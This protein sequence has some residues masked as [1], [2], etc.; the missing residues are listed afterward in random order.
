MGPRIP[1]GMMEMKTG[2]VGSPRLRAK[3]QKIRGREKLLEYL[4]DT[5]L[6]HFFEDK[7]TLEEFVKA[8]GGVRAKKSLK[9][10]KA[11]YKWPDKF[12]RK[13]REQLQAIVFQQKLDARQRRLKAEAKKPQSLMKPYGKKKVKAFI[14]GTVNVEPERDHRVVRRRASGRDLSVRRRGTEERTHLKKAN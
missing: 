14:L 6:R 3:V 12:G 9:A 13:L 1:S 7:E 4:S 8:L 5:I 10:L 2:A 11:L